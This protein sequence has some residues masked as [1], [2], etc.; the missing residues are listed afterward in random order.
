MEQ[1]IQTALGILVSV[2]L[3]IV[4]YRQTIGARKERVRACNE[5]IIETIL[6]RLILEKY[7]PKKEDIKKLIEGK[8]RDYKVKQKDL[9]SEDQ[10]LNTL[11]T[12]IFENDLISQEQRD[13]N[14]ERLSALF[15]IDK[16]EVKQDLEVSLETIYRKKKFVNLLS[17]IMAIVSSIIGVFVVSLYQLSDLKSFMNSGILIT[18]LGSI[19]AIFA[20]YSFLRLKDNQESSEEIDLPK[21]PFHDYVKF[22][23]EV[24][25]QLRKLN[26]ETI[27]PNKDEGF[28]LIAIIR[29]EK[30]AIEIKFWRQ[31]PPFGFIRQVLTKLKNGMDK[32]GIKK[33]LLIANDKFGLN[34]KLKIEDS[35]EILTINDL[36]N[37]IK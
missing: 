32:E 14:I 15:I 6:R 23:Q 10:I 27:M 30:V 8:A 2:L 9:L 11:Y 1:Y 26:I 18:M 13:N 25:I 29:G 24:V 3:F 17:L 35:I 34:D 36:K 16:K 12:R 21:N 28:D 19:L 4:G 20:V 22:E 33:G 31:R 5:K 37:L 7:T